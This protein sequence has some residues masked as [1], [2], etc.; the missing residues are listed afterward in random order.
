MLEIAE[1]ESRDRSR[2]SSI[3]PTHTTDVGTDKDE[4]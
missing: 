2:T 3:M 1:K 4:K